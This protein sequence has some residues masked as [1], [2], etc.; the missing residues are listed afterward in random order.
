MTF[1]TEPSIWKIIETEKMQKK[2]CASL[3][4]T[5]FVECMFFKMQNYIIEKSLK[6]PRD[7]KRFCNTY[8]SDFSSLFEKYSSLIML[9]II[10]IW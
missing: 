10:F 8:C 7:L 5:F 3:L 4:K 6:I 2:E 9:V 1:V